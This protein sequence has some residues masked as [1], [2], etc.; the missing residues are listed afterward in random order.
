MGEI[1]EDLR[2]VKTRAAIDEAFTSL[3]KEKSF[4]DINVKDIAK[5]A[6]I[7]RGAFYM[8]YQDKHKLLT[9][10]ENELLEG[11]SK[12]LYDG[13]EENQKLTSDMPKK[14]AAKTFE[15]VDNNHE[16]II[17]LFNNTGV[18]H[19][20]DKIQEHMSGYYHKKA[21]EILNENEMKVTLD[22]LIAYITGAHI[23]LMK[24]W[25]Q[26]GRAETWEEL[27]E[28]LEIISVNGP[29]Y[30]TGLSKE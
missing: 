26:N 7:S 1:K 9:D 30:A 20:E 5:R 11:L 28:I 10:Y 29:F 22:Y 15:F 3:I 4:N 14:I 8:H 27:A 25:L 19:L 16:K 18:T 12:N 17:A 24:K 13:I 6:K 21:K 23:S 2:K